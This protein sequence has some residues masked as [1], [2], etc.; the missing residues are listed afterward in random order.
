[1]KRTFLAATLAAVAFC[2]AASAADRIRVIANGIYNTAKPDLSDAREFDYFAE[3]A[4]IT[5]NLSA[6]GGFG[7]DV[8]FQVSLYKGLGVL[9][10]YSMTSRS[11]SGT[12]DARFP[13]PLFLNR[14]RS[15]SGEF[16]GFDYQE[17]AVHLDVAYVFGQGALEWVLFGGAS[18]FSVEADLVDQVVV[19]QSYPYDEIALGS[20]QAT[21][22]KESPVGFNIGG[23]LDYRLGKSRRFGIG[24][25]VRYS[26]AAV[27]L[28]AASEASEVSFDAGGFEVGAGIRIYF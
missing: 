6:E 10:G 17:K 1:L 11:E 13:H 24:A 16:S 22:V 4:R 28:R 8:A 7:P 20:V 25:L 26:T 2:P 15:L 23:R 12:F 3:T 27:T 21:T 18:F 14:P 19:S 5:T 9:V